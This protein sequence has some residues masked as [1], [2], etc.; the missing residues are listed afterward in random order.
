MRCFSD[1]NVWC[2]RFGRSGLLS[3][4]QK[5]W[6]PGGELFYGNFWQVNQIEEVGDLRSLQIK[7]TS[8]LRSQVWKGR[9]QP[10]Q[11]SPF[12]CHE[13]GCWRKVTF[14][15]LVEPSLSACFFGLF[16]IACYRSEELQIISSRCLADCTAKEKCCQQRAWCDPRHCDV[17]CLATHRLSARRLD[18]VSYYWS[19]LVFVLFSTASGA[20]GVVPFSEKHIT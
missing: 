9:Q 8:D 12:C 15:F 18:N 6:Q 14:Q 3:S 4:L 2:W 7:E 19:Y 16:T 17:R 13:A 10:D 11:I 20:L 1:E 5:W